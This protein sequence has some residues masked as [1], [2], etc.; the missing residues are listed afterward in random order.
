M[1]I[2]TYQ[3][4]LKVLGYYNGKCD[5]KYS[6]ELEKAICMFQKNWNLKKTGRRNKKTTKQLAKRYKLYIAR[7]KKTS[8][9]KYSWQW[10][11]G[12]INWNKVE[13]LGFKRNEFA[14]K[15]NKYCNGYPHKINWKI[16]YVAIKLKKKYEKPIQITCGLRCRKHNAELRGSVPNSVHL[17]GGAID[18]YIKGVTDTRS[19]RDKVKRYLRSLPYVK[20]TYSD[21]PNMGSAIHVNV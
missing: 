18:F 4:Y 3:S 5:G 19:G 12:D 13:K 16:V 8:K 20:Y 21:T 2:K 6:E 11:N 17:K 10:G 15:C 14:C 1:T 9:K 7:H